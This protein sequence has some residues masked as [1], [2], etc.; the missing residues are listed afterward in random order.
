MIRRWTRILTNM[1]QIGNFTLVQ[2]SEQ[3]VISHRTLVKDIQS[4]QE[5][6]R[7]IEKTLG[8]RFTYRFPNITKN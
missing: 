4:M 3:M 2:L 7:C 5:Y 8:N 6:F 1:E